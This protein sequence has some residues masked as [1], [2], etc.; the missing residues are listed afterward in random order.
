M[1]KK[2]KNDGDPK[3]VAKDEKYDKKLLKKDRKGMK[4]A[5]IANELKESKKDMGYSKMPKVKP[6][7]KK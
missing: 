1:G 4:T 5:G 6:Q 3:Y 7:K 2:L